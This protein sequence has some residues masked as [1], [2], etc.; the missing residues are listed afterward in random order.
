MAWL[1]APAHSSVDIGAAIAVTEETGLT[2][3]HA[4]ARPGI[5]HVQQFTRHKAAE[6]DQSRVERHRAIGNDMAAR[7]GM[8]AVGADDE[9][10]FGA[11]T[12][13]EMRGN[14]S[15]GAVLDPD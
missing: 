1:G 2:E 11:R 10:A 6:T 7:D 15:V 13:L 12:I 9:I 5:R 8:H 14:G 3:S 4:Q